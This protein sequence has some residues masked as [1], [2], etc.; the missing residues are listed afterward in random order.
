MAAIIPPGY[1]GFCEVRDR[2]FSLWSID[3]RSKL[4]GLLVTGELRAWR[5]GSKGEAAPIP[6]N[7]WEGSEGQ[8]LCEMRRDQ[9]YS[10]GGLPVFRIEDLREKLPRLRERQDKLDAE[11]RARRAQKEGSA[12]AIVAVKNRGGAPV[13]YDWDAMWI[14]VVRIVHSEG[15]PK[16]ASDFRKRLHQW[17]VDT[18]RPDPGETE[19]KKK[20]SALYAMKRQEETKG[21]N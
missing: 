7:Y 1:E 5:A 20:F 14:E 3:A 4:L 11:K 10:E 12:T 6:P 2:A 17:F 21:S 9:L 13:T 19:M 15:Y 16:N 8:R 18:N